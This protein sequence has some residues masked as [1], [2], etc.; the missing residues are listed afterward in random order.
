VAQPHDF[1]IHKSPSSLSNKFARRPVSDSKRWHP[2]TALHTAVSLPPTSSPSPQRWGK[3]CPT[4]SQPPSSY[5]VSSPSYCSSS[6]SSASTP[7]SR[8]RSLC[9]P[10]HSSNV[11]D[12]NFDFIFTFTASQMHNSVARKT[13]GRVKS[14]STA[15]TRSTPSA[16]RPLCADFWH[17]R[18][19]RHQCL[20]GAAE[21]GIY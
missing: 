7:L 2:P 16:N 8:V 13:V 20:G 6:F 18:A 12:P 19:V 21:P 1:S 11:A 14:S 15:G 3:S 9:S 5:L 17:R 4:S 10:I